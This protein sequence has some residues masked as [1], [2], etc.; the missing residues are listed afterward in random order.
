MTDSSLLAARSAGVLL[1]VTSLP[2]GYG[3]GDLGPA[4]HDWIDLLAGAGQRWWQILPLGPV[5]YGGSPYSS[6]SSL[7][8]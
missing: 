6:S 3:I 4:A 2:A 8:I 7:A 5:G 1:H